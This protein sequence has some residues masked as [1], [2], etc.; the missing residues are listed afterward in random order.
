LHAPLVDRSREMPLWSNANRADQ[1]W[2][3]SIVS[4]ARLRNFH[5]VNLRLSAAGLSSPSA[6]VTFDC[7]GTEVILAKEGAPAGLLTLP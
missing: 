2:E 1:S 5:D 4:P 3:Q 7:I 6:A